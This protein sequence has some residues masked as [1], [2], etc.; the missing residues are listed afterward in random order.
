MEKATG[1]QTEI[2]KIETGQEVCKIKMLFFQE[3][4]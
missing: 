2:A 3:E 1:K 4:D